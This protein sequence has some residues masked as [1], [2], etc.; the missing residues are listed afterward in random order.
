MF[1]IGVLFLIPGKCFT[2]L[3]TYG[4]YICF[5]AKVEPFLNIKSFD[6]TIWAVCSE[7]LG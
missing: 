7:L 6:M 3:F 5:Y 1:L 4:L 2:E